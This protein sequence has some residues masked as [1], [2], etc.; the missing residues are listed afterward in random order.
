[1]EEI[2]EK[3]PAFSIRYKLIHSKD[4]DDKVLEALN[5]IFP[6]VSLGKRWYEW[7]TYMSPQGN[8]LWFV[9]E[10]KKGKII[11]TYGFLPMQ[12]KICDYFYNSVLAVNTGIIPLYW[13]KGIYQRFSNFAF[14]VLF[15][16]FNKKLI[17][18]VPNNIAYTSHLRLGWYDIGKLLFINLSE[19]EIVKNSNSKNCKVKV[20]D[21]KNIPKIINPFLKEVFQKY[22]LFVNKNADFIKWR[23]SRSDYKGNYRFGLL[24]SDGVISGY[25]IIKIYED[26]EKN[27]KKIHI[28]DINYMNKRDLKEL[29]I[30]ACRIVIDEEAD[31]L[32]ISVY[33]CSELYNDFIELGFRRDNKE[34]HLLGYAVDEEIRLLL[35]KVKNVHFALGDNDIY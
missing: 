6:H 9:G 27:I 28:V 35:K 34:R 19:K 18:A 33:I 4:Y 26:N 17:V 25:I 31:V 15:N 5:R 11:A 32:N 24:E 7:F 12:I 16:E 21:V 14:K 2:V 3:D 22:N 10:D 1:M 20:V 30:F 29:V 8:C 13:G 23:Y